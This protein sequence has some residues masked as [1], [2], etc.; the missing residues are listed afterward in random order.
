MPSQ[1]SLLKT[2][3]AAFNNGAGDTSAKITNSNGI[4]QYGKYGINGVDAKRVY[5]IV[6]GNEF[7]EKDFLNNTNDIQTTIAKHLISELTTQQVDR[8]VRSAKAFI[9]GYS[10]TGE[11][12][13]NKMYGGSVSTRNIIH[14][15]LNGY[16][17]ND[18]NFTIYPRLNDGDYEMRMKGIGTENLRINNNYLLQYDN[19]NVG[20]VVH[21][22]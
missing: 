10:T 12:Y 7:N 3:E 8:E 2:F 20:G 15:W 6:T 13:D 14:G 11:V 16:N 9:S 4:I 21:S 5:K 18:K 17:P 1:P 22:W 19:Y